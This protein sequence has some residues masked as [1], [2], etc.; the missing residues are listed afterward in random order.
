M[1]PGP[2]EAVDKDALQALI[3][4]QVP[5][6]KTI[7]YKREI[8]ST[9]ES[10]MIPLLATVSSFANT[11]GGDLLI[12]IEADKGVPTKLL[13]VKTNDTD[14]EKL[15]L[16]Q[17]LRSGIEPRLPLVEIHPILI[18]NDKHTY[19][20]LEFI[21]AGLLRTVWFGT[22]SFMLAI[23]RVVMNLMSESSGRPLTCQRLSPLGSATFALIA[24]HE[25]TVARHQS[26]LNRVDAWWFTF[27]H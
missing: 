24:L 8:P 16:E 25:Y 2:I 27:F 14:A 10:M 17:V 18:G 5:E 19:G 13:G 1:V 26:L 3:D 12:G 20:Q 9:A 23:P 4:N 22:A 11:A 15:Q 6:G 7:E 21:V